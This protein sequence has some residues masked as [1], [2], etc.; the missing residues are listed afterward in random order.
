MIWALVTGLYD[1]NDENSVILYLI[2]L[3][4]QYTFT[5]LFILQ[6]KLIKGINFCLLCVRLYT[7]T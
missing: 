6:C 4:S 3:S 5:Y 7:S 1:Y 2:V